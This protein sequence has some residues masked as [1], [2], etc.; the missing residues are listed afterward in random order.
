[1]H[2]DLEAKP[3]G[4]KIQSF[5]KLSYVDQLLELSPFNIHTFQ[6]EYPKLQSQEF[7]FGSIEKHVLVIRMRP[8]V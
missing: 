2:N 6:R 3:S 5:V 8:M 4:N 1:M 7:Q